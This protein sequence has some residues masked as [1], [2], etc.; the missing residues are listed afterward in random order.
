MPNSRAMEQGH[1]VDPLRHHRD[2]QHLHGA[3][4]TDR[5]GQNA[6]RVARFFGTPRYILGQTL[7]VVAWIALNAAVAGL[8]W[9]PYPFILLTSPSP[10]RPPT[11]PR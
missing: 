2:H 7:L 5:F 4:G 11:P 6:E 9:D 1:T 8:R 10:P 3:F